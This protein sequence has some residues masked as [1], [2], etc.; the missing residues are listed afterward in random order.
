MI[1][2]QSGFHVF[3]EYDLGVILESQASH[4]KKD[5]ESNIK[6][7][8]LIDDST[9]ILEKIEKHKIYP[10]EFLDDQLTVTAEER[11]IPAKYFSS[12][13]FVQQGSSYPKQVLR[14]HLPFKRR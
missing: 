3:N 1:F 5:I 6:S 13:F 9:Y 11:M 7:Q 4:A 10:L 8:Q 2:N 12:D 14:F